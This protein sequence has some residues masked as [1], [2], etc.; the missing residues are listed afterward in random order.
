M[1][2]ETEIQIT[3]LDVTT[4]LKRR[5]TAELHKVRA[6]RADLREAYSFALKELLERDRTSDEFDSFMTRKMKDSLHRL[7]QI[8]ACNTIEA[9]LTKALTTHD[10]RPDVMTAYLTGSTIDAY[11]YLWSA[12]SRD[13]AEHPE[14]WQEVW[15]EGAR[16]VVGMLLGY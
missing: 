13:V 9:A 12:R 2:T 1:N 14:Y 10:E 16:R 15:A 11:G 8:E 4:A 6:E 7:R 3:T 5:I